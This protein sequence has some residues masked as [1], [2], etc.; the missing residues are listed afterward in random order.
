MVINHLVAGQLLNLFKISNALAFRQT[1]VRKKACAQ[2]DVF[3]LGYRLISFKISNGIP[4]FEMITQPP[5][6]GS[7]LSEE[8]E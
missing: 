1:V 5:F 4:C 8:C 6:G 7:F 3:S 2:S